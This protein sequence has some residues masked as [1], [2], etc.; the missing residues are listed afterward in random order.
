MVA[1]L[2]QVTRHL[3]LGVIFSDIGND[4]LQK[5]IIN[6][7]S[8]CSRLAGLGQVVCVLAT[9]DMNCPNAEAYYIGVCRSIA[10]N[11]ETMFATN[12]Q[13]GQVFFSAG[14]PPAYRAMKDT[15]GL[16]ASHV[17]SRA[18]RRADDAKSLALKTGRS[19]S[20]AFEVVAPG[21]SEPDT[22]C[23]TYT[24]LRC[25]LCAGHGCGV[26]LTFVHFVNDGVIAL[27]PSLAMA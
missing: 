3:L 23:A 24:P 4:V 5:K 11:D 21:H 18:G 13:T 27:A 14:T 1:T 12:I 19:Q 8:A 2:L 15:A 9:T 7:Q 25:D 22:V 6:V 20:C 17:C 26:L 10:E 16:A